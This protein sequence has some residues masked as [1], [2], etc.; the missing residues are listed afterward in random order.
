MPND[1]LFT[2][3]QW[4]II[5]GSLL[6]DGY[7]TKPK[8]GNSSFA[9]N[10][11]LKHE[12]YLKWHFDKFKDYSCPVKYYDNYC[13][14]IKYKR[15]SYRTKSNLAFTALRDKWYLNNT[16]T[17]PGDL[18]LNPL[19]IAIWFFDDGSNSLKKR[20]CKFSTYC[21]TDIECDF[22][23]RQLSYFQIKCSISKRNEIL[24]K[25]ESY[26]NIV[27]L[28][29]PFMLWDC[30]NHKIQYRDSKLEFTTDEEAAKIFEEF[31]LGKTQRQIAK[32]MGKSCSVVS[33]ILRNRNESGLSLNNTSGVKG[34]YWDK[35]RNRWTA[36]GKKNGKSIN[37]GRFKNKEE[38]IAARKAYGL[39]PDQLP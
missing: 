3:E 33:S 30:F 20:T 10:Q 13:R 26:K 16:K 31:A 25:C 27:D 34:V 5:N 18:V 38:A 28:V 22:L 35:S 24:V 39:V 19:T 4:A 17:I 2:D 23:C 15:V 11:C 1:Y 14:G 29:S 21:F 37:L 8:H 9:K 36:L 6:G 12:L 7:I 32:D